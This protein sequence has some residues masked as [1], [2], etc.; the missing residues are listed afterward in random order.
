[1]KRTSIAFQNITLSKKLKGG[2]LYIAIMAGVIIGIIL[3]MFILIAKYNQRT[4]TEFTQN[5]QLYYNLKSAFELARSEYLTD[6][7]DHQW[8]KNFFN[9]DSIRVRKTYWGAYQVIIAETKNRHHYLSQ[10]GIYGTPMSADTGIMVADNSRPMGVSGTVTFK[11]NCYLPQAGIKPSYIEGQSYNSNSQNSSYIKP[12]P[13]QIPR[14]QKSI[15][16]GLQKQQRSISA[17]DS[18]VNV[19]PEYFNRSFILGTVAWHNSANILTHLNLKNNIKIICGNIEVDS[20]SR[21]ENILIICNKARFKN[22]F[23]GKVHVIASDSII[24][25]KNCEFEYPSSFVLLPTDNNSNSFNYI[26]FNEGCRFFGAVLALN[27]GL[28]GSNQ[29]VFVKLHAKSEVNGFIY[30]GDFMHLEGTVN[31]TAICNKLLLKT[32]SAVYENHI[33]ACEINPHKHGHLLAVP[34]VFNERSP[35]V[36]CEKVN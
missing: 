21:L 29:K 36:C 10:T 24:M 18:V 22:G 30:S 27:E 1:M 33:L 7:S 6:Q 15:I 3:T 13:F 31:A 16:T 28:P 12:A 20:S 5:S 17:S 35:L 26:N 9:D 34:L 8:I 4:V 25:E 2:A 32:P 11:A 23:K 14:I 19:L